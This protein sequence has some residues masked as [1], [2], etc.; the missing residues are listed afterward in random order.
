MADYSAGLT[1]RL[2]WLQESRKTASFMTEGMT[3]DEI[4][5]IAWEKNI[6]QVKAQYRAVEILKT[7]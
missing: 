7:T 5:K 6:Y 2:F 1:S 3:K 4:R